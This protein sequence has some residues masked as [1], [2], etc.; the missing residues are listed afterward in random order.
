MGLSPPIKDGLELGL[1]VWCWALGHAGFH[2]AQKKHLQLMA[3]LQCYVQLTWLVCALAQGLGQG[4]APS[5]GRPGLGFISPS[6][7][8]WAAM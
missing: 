4:A 3:E 5:A 8:P 1:A 2:E 6:P 7:F